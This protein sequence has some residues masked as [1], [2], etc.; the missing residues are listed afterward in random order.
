MITCTTSVCLWWGKGDLIVQNGTS[1]PAIW[2]DQGKIMHSHPWL[3]NLCTFTAYFTIKI[4]WKEKMC[5]CSCKVFKESSTSTPRF[6]LT[7][8]HLQPYSEKDIYFFKSESK[9]EITPKKPHFGLV[10]QMVHKLKHGFEK[11]ETGLW[12]SHNYIFFCHAIVMESNNI[13]RVSIAQSL[14]LFV[15]PLGLSGRWR[16]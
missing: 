13:N 3:I 2:N 14:K 4:I 12:V 1:Q 11:R 9:T 6:A 8:M 16:Q 5:S 10:Y 7:A 15:Y